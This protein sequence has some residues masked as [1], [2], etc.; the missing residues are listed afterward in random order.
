MSSRTSSPRFRFSRNVPETRIGSTARTPQM[1]PSLVAS[2][3]T[4]QFVFSKP[5][6]PPNLATKL[7]TWMPLPYQS[8]PDESGDWLYWLLVAG[9]GTGKTDA[10]AHYVDSYARLHPGARIAVIAP[11]TGD[12][13]A[14]CVEGETGLLAAN[15]AVRFNR[16]WGELLWPNGSKAQLF[17]AY[18]PDDA[19]R[20]RGP[21]HHLVWCD[22]FAAWRQLKA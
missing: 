2:R 11:T 14:V 16:S 15:N 21:Q 20:L 3:W 13:R 10:G 9:R 7:S 4:R 12:A 22:E 5:S 18:N 6:S 8:P 17:G 19:E 1:S